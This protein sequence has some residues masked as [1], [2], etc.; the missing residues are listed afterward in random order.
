VK[1]FLLAAGHGTRLAPLTDSVPKI[2]VPLAGRPLLEHQLE[3]LAFNGVSE[4]ILNVHH[5]ADRVLEFV[6]GVETPIPVCVS[7]E[8]ELLGTAGALAPLRED[9]CETFVLLYGD[10]ITD[11]PLAGL[12]A[13]H[14][15]RGGIATLA[16]CRTDD[17]RGKG[18]IAVDAAGRITGF[19]EKPH[20]VTAGA[21]VNAGLYVLDPE[22]FEF[23]EPGSSFGAD[24][25][26]R[27]LSEGRPVYAY[28]VTGYV[29]D[30]GTPEALSR[31]AR[32]LAA[33]AVSWPW[34]AARSAA[35]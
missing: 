3:Y 27:A 15:S 31:A 7:R 4:V 14:E 26:P 23:V 19:A 32:D 1:A 12:I 29:R 17:P 30:I 2:L 24:V 5:L 13:A 8:P 35:G 28:R 25:W 9:L 18:V 34:A 20:E 6:E 21:T 22:I 10:V 11:E 16:C 33:G